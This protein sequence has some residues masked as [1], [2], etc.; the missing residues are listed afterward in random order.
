MQDTPA[1]P[2]FPAGS[3]LPDNPLPG[4]LLLLCI[5]LLVCAGIKIR[6]WWA[7]KKARRDH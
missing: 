5:F 6:L 7:E 3:S 2:P 1:I 4:F